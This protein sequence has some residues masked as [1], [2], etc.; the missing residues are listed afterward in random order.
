M[1]TLEVLMR[2]NTTRLSAG[3]IA[4]LASIAFAEAQPAPS[5]DP[6][7]PDAQAQGGRPAKPM[8]PPPGRPAGPGMAGDMMGGNMEHMMPM[9]RM[10]QSMHAMQMMD[11]MMPREGGGMAMMPGQHIEGR[12]A[13]LKTELGITEAQLPQWN[14]FA[15]AM[16]E[17]AKSMQAAMTANMGAGM[18]AT[19]P[20]RSDAMVAM[21]TARLETTKK[22]SESGKALYAVLTDAQKKSADDLMMSRMAGMGM[23]GRG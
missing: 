18:P 1:K 22:V 5:A 17:G 4:L 14:A 10:M 3:A 6:H 20:A 2:T 8:T 15:D 11:G 23:G 7:H 16:R 19:A 21:M 12:I 13:F 9:M